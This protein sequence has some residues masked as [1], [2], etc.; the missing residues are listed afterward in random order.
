MVKDQRMGLKMVLQVIP[1]DFPMDFINLMKNWDVIIKSPYGHSYYS[2]QPG[3]DYKEPDSYRISD[4]WNFS[5]KG[6]VHCKT[7]SECPNNS[8]WTIAKFNGDLQKYEVIQSIEKPI[9]SVKSTREFKIMYL[10]IRWKKAIAN[11]NKQ[12]ISPNEI[13]KAISDSE[14]FFL[15]KKYEILESYQ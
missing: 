14:L 10:E 7:T 8:H 1:K 6:T 12:L 13:K 5:A 2:A 11:I 3:W 4:H 9:E 15:N